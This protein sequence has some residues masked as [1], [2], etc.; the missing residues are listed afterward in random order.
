M[1]NTQNH[2]N[3][4]TLSRISSFCFHSAIA[5]RKIM[6][7]FFC[8]GQMTNCQTRN[9]QF[10]HNQRCDTGMINLLMYGE[11]RDAYWWTNGGRTNERMGGYFA[12]THTHTHG[13]D[14]VA[15]RRWRCRCFGWRFMR[16]IEFKKNFRNLNFLHF[17]FAT[18]MQWL[19]C[20]ERGRI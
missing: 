1:Y 13:G 11:I 19:T 12:I 15:G 14:L 5:M 6:Y 7:L 2:T 9:A 18:A 4:Y 10:E 17:F 3:I 16:C 20:E 8:N